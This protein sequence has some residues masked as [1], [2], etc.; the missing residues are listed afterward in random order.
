MDHGPI[1]LDAV[2]TQSKDYPCCNG[3]MGRDQL[4][5][6]GSFMPKGFADR[7]TPLGRAP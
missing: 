4:D 1:A 5:V 3:N 7:E 6:N 2:Q